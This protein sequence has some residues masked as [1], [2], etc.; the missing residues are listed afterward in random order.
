MAV[1]IA[2]AA[3]RLLVHALVAPAL[4]LTR[5]MRYLVENSIAQGMELTPPEMSVGQYLG[6]TRSMVLSGIQ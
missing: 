1:A 3:R 2:L 6:N 4:E 5:T